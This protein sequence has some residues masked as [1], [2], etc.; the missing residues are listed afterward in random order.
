M[1]AVP[2]PVKTKKGFPSNFLAV[3]AEHERVV[4]L[5]GALAV[6][7]RQ[8]PSRSSCNCSSDWFPGG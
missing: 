1:H 3:F 4:T 6:V 2:T 7:V 5:V 8:I